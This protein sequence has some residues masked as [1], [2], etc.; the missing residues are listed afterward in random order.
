M[1][2]TGI[3]RATHFGGLQSM[4]DVFN[5]H[6]VDVERGGV[7]YK[8]ITAFRHYF[9]DEVIA[10]MEVIFDT[11]QEYTDWVNRDLV[12]ISRSWAW[13]YTDYK[14]AREAIKAIVSETGFDTLT[15]IEQKTVAKWFAC[16]AQQQEDVLTLQEKIEAG[17]V[18]NA[19]SIESRNKRF[20]E[21]M[22]Y[23][24]N[25]LD[26]PTASTLRQRI[27]QEQFEAR[28]VKLGQEGTGVFNYAGMEDTEG[29]FDFVNSTV[30]TSYEGTG[31]AT[32]LTGLKYNLTV[33]EVIAHVDTLLRNGVA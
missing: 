28:Y 22:A 17:K 10:Q 29:V 32:Y 11:Q 23:L 31:L 15:E 12:Y 19:L 26:F 5:G 25:I 2:K 27:E 21:V 3:I 6:W 20:N 30:G 9:T 18:F 16:T 8:S 4:P 13:D 7:P 24:W 1:V 14:Q 33:S